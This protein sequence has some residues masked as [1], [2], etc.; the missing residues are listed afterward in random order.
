MGHS[1]FPGART[2]G[3][4]FIKG[5]EKGR[6]VIRP[7]VIITIVVVDHPPSIMRY[8]ATSW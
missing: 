6:Q 1:I 8:L 7:F 2:G 4:E 5:G 3:K